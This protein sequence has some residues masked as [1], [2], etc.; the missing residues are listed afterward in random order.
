MLNFHDP[1]LMSTRS[2]YEDYEMPLAR[3]FYDI[4]QRGIAVDSARLQQLR[5]WIQGELV[6]SCTQIS[7]NLGGR[8]V[9][10]SKPN[11][12]YKPKPGELNLSSPL[13]IIDAL[14]SIGLNPPKKRREGGD[15]TESSDEE[16]LNELFAETGN[17]V[18]KEILRVRE[19]NKILGTNVNAKL[20]DD[21]LYGA[22]FVTGTV[23]GRRSCRENFLGLGTNHQNQPKHSDLGKKYRECLVARAG[24]LIVACDQA[25]AED[26]VIQGLIADSSGN[27]SG[28]DDLAKGGRHEKL[29]CFIFAKPPDQIRYDIERYMAKKTRYAGSYDMGAFRFASEMAKEGHVVSEAHCAWLLSQFHSFE[30]AIK[31]VFQAD[32]QKQLC[33]VRTLTTP[34]GRVRQFLGLRDFSNNH[35]IF[36]EGYAQVPQSTVGDNTG[37]A[38][39]WL[40]SNYPGH[41]IMESHDSV[42]LEIADNL[43]EFIQACRMLKEAFNR[44]IRFKNGTEVVIPIEIEFGYDLEHMVKVKCDPSNEV[45]LTSTYLSLPKRPSPP[46]VSISGVPPASSEQHSNVTYG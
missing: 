23:T 18:L 33:A 43:H 19:L 8:L 25:S 42:D 3:A 20:A 21:T 12:K 4:N 31:N 36:K 22:Y 16:A 6:T 5:Q 45:G 46:E 17:P 30:P 1:G 7:Q 2:F 9:I 24:R 40:E 35:K 10:A 44:I 39:L 38:I 34:F 27:R 13:Q 37:M 26:W 14:K 29:A 15:Y 28:L 41:V 11:D 32:V